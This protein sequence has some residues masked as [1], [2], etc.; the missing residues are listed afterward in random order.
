MG[1][2]VGRPAPDF[3]EA[4]VVNGSTFVDSCQLSSYRGKYVVLFFY[5][6]DFTFV[7]PTELHAF[8]EK[9]DEFKKR[10]VEVLGCSVDSKFSHFAWLNTPRSKGGIQ[11]VT[12]PL[13]SD[14]NK[15]I[16]RDYDVL[17]PDGSVALR[18]LF[19]IDRE[20]VVKHQVVNDLG[21]GRNIDEVLRIVDALQFTEEFGE[22]C[23]ANWNKGD[24][25]MKPTDE[26]LKEYFAE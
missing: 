22:V 5:P 13:I 21:L 25:T 16:A 14:I 7:C 26:G 9:I 17:T 23:P 11:G 18:G 19:L 24:K 1:V 4:A 8:Q 10:N 20:G 12:Y 15:T 2:L 6:L 3:N